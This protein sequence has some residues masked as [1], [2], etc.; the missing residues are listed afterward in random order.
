MEI[1]GNVSR[2]FQDHVLFLMLF[3]NMKESRQF[4]ISVISMV[5][6]GLYFF[7]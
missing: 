2:T 1:T 3:G 4:M 7:D 5:W 6:K